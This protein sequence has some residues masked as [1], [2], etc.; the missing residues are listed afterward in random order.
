MDMIGDKDLGIYMEKNSDPLLTAEIWEQAEITGIFTILY[1]E[2][3]YSI[4]DDH[5]PFLEKGFPAVDLI[6]F[7]YPYWHTTSDTVDKVSPESLKIVGETLTA[8]ISSK[9]SQK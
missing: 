5:I 1:S 2:Y 3:K 4:L 6:D 9:A 7:D 8:W